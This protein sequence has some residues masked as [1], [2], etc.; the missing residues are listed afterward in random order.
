LVAFLVER[1]FWASRFKDLGS[2]QDMYDVIGN[3]VFPFMQARAA[4]NSSGVQNFI[5][6]GLAAFVEG[7]VAR[8]AESASSNF[9][10]SIHCSNQPI[11]AAMQ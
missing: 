3:Y 7:G 8:S 6:G 4:N 1:R 11:P 2:A 9:V 5:S 10:S